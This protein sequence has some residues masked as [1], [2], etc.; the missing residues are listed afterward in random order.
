L[1]LRWLTRRDAPFTFK[2]TWPN[3]ADRLNV[4]TV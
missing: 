3:G 1:M 2:G 4:T